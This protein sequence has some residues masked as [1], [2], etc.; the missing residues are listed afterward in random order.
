MVG[1]PPA[2]RPAVEVPPARSRKAWLRVGLAAAVAGVLGGAVTAGIVLRTRATHRG[3]LVMTLEARTPGDLRKAADILRTRLAGDGYD[4]PRVTVTGDRTLSVSVGAGA[5][6]DGLRELAQPG[7]LSFRA[8]V[9][10]PATP[11]TSAS[12]PAGTGPV[13]PAVIAKLG[14]AY[15]AAQAIADPGQV[16]PGEL[17]ALAP[18]GTLTPDEVAR[19]P[20][21]MQYAVPAIT[22][23]QLNGRAAGAIDDPATAVTAC[24][25]TGDQNKYLLDPAT[26][27]AADI[28]GAHLELQPVPGWTVTIAFTRG[29]QPRWTALTRAALGNRPSNQVA[30]VVDNQVISAPAIQAVSTGDAAISG[31]GIDRTAAARLAALLRSGPLPVAFTVSGIHR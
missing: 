3:G 27:T 24:E 4:H 11:H 31:A 29:G 12:A 25:R 14:T 10:G 13:P 21:T 30:I 7:R 15:A 20:A 1:D 26:V 19:L 5:D 28:A 2:V 16:D 6:A 23:A 8:V 22:C 17:A 18:F 9:A